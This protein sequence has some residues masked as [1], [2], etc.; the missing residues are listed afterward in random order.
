MNYPKSGGEEKHYL[1]VQYGYLA[2]YLLFIVM[3]LTGLV[4]AFEEVKWLDPI[5]KISNKIHSIVQYGLYAYI[6]IHII[7]VIRADMTKYGGIVS[8]MING[9]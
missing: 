3:A 6:I 1:F 8:R 9:K 4:L 5:H 7:G 2:F